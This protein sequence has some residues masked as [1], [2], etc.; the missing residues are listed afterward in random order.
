MKKILATILAFIYLSTS[1]GATV[2]FHYCMG[3]LVSWGLMEQ[4]G[5]SCTSCGM[6]KKDTA[7]HCVAT[8]KGCCKDE[9]QQIKTGKDQ[10]VVQ[11]EF[12]FLKAFPEAC[13]ANHSILQVSPVSPLTIDYPTAN[14]PPGTGKVPLFLLNRNFRI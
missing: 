5:K 6:P 1:V 11:S 2:H 8:K 7:N 14:A 10:K 4:K 3:R 9:H 12:E 13:V